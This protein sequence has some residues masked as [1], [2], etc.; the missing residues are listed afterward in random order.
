[1]KLREAIEILAN[2]QKGTW[3]TPNSDFDDAI[4]LGIEAMKRIRLSRNRHF[5][6]H[7]DLLPGETED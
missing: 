2:S 5:T 4:Q 7:D 3:P 6:L 1:M